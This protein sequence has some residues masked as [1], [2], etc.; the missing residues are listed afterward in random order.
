M[1]ASEPWR[2]ILRADIV[3]GL[4][5]EE[6]SRALLVVDQTHHDVGALDR[7]PWFRSAS[8]KSFSSIRFR[9]LLAAE[10]LD[11]EGTVTSTWQVPEP[12]CPLG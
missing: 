1:A 9:A 7:T 6:Q 2:S 10:D 4:I 3:V 12:R 11:G 5:N 8:R